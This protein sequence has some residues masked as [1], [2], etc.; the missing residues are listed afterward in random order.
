MSDVVILMQTIRALILSGDFVMT[1]HFTDRCRERGLASAAVVQDTAQ[2]HI[3]ENYPDD[4][5]G[6]SCLILTKSGTY[7]LHVVVGAS[8]VEI[9]MITAYSPNPGQW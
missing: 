8:H 1:E 4:P 6:P 7:T 3:I 5:R 9:I 2:G